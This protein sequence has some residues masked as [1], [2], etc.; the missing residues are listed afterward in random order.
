MTAY[1]DLLAKKRK[2]LGKSQN[3]FAN[4][5]K[6]SVQA[7]AKYEK[8][9]AEMNVAQLLSAAKFLEVD[10]DSLLQGIDEKKNDCADCTTFDPHRFARNLRN[11]RLSCYLSYDEMAQKIGVSARSLKNYEKG[12]EPSFANHF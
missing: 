2:Y 8:G 9:Q 12:T 1:A 4:A 11:S 10:P 6:Y 7:V 5:L 3:D